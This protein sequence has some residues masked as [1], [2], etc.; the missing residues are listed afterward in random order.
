MWEP[1]RPV[2]G[3]A[4]IEHFDV[5]VRLLTGVLEVLG[6]LVVSLSPQT[7]AGIIRE[8]VHEHFLLHPF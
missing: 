7:Y 8:L 6:L 2:T 3:I 4:F 1:R 5:A